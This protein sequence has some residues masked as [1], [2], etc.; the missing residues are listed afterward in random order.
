M[1]TLLTATRRRRRATV[2]I[3]FV[4][5]LPALLGLL[6]MSVDLGRMMLLNGYLSDVAYSTARAGA[7]SGQPQDTVPVA[8]DAAVSHGIPMLSDAA[9]RMSLV[10][11]EWGTSSGAG[12]DPIKGRCTV[13]R[14]Y[15][16]VAASMDVDFI[17][18]GL[19]NLIEMFGEGSDD[20]G[21]DSTEGI[22]MKTAAV[23]LCQ[24]AE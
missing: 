6:L 24:V 11:G 8:F 16:V 14:P 10:D 21:F 18:P 5:V 17:T 13:G 4:A 19:S 1:R 9:S 12:S 23:S 3:E 15:V 7:Q 20:S 2:M 22:Q